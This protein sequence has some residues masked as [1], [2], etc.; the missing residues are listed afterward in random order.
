M[1]EASRF[2]FRLGFFMVHAELS[3]LSCT[4]FKSSFERTV[5]GGFLERIHASEMV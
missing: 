4:H 2:V 1:V 5:L 3:S